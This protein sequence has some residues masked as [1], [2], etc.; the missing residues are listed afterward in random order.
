MAVGG[1]KAPF[2]QATK[3]TAEECCAE[4]GH[5]MHRPAHDLLEPWC[6]V[7]EKTET[8]LAAAYGIVG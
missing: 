3:R 4:V 2:D 8:E 5:V 7:C 1:K 6:L